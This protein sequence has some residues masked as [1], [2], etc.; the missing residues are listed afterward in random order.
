MYFL[1][2][3]VV[4]PSLVEERISYTPS[5]EKTF[6]K[7][8]ASLDEVWECEYE[9][10]LILD[11]YVLI[12]ILLRSGL[13]IRLVSCIAAQYSHTVEQFCMARVLITFSDVS[14]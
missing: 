13:S 1:A 12:I 3:L 11:N 10:F 6:E 7:V 14:S 5:N 4:T 8:I 9:S 2:G